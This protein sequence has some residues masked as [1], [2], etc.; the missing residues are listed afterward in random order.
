MQKKLFGLVKTTLIDYP[1]EVA[2]TIFTRGCNLRCPYCHNPDFVTNTN[3][4][5][6]FTWDAILDFLKKRAKIIGGVCITGGEPLL[7]KDLPEKIEEI[8]SLGLLVKVDTNGTLPECLKKIKA[9]Y[10][11]MDIKTSLKNYSSMGYTGNNNLLIDKITESI[12]IIKKSKIPHHFRTTIVP[13]FVNEDTIKEI[14]KLVKG[15]NYY[16][17]QKF[18]AEKTL[19]PGLANLI[20]FPQKDLES[21]K[22]LFIS[23]GINCI[24]K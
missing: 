20:P 5:Y 13:G 17:L 11:A 12:E 4:G 3:E 9:D 7:H 8:H 1:G 22:N 16:V 21:M 14:I 18:R 2:S 23:A 15:E 24:L 10:L 6:L 19:D